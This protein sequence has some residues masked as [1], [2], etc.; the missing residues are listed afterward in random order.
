MKLYYQDD[1]VTLYHGDSLKVLPSLNIEAQV[2][3]TD[4]PYFK[5]KQDEWDNQ[6]DKASEFLG[7]MGSILDAAKPLLTEHASAWVFASPAMTSSVER[8]VGERF[9]VLNSIRWA[10]NGGDNLRRV[11]LPAIRSF[12]SIW[13]G[14][15][16]AE[17]F[18]DAYDAASKALRREVFTPLGDYLRAE[19]EHAGWKAGALGVALGYDSAMPS[20][21]AEGSS[22]PTASA[23]QRLR[24]TLNAAGGDYLAREYGDLVAENARLLAEFESQRVSIEH[25]RRPFNITDRKLSEDIWHFPSVPGYPGKHSC[26]KPLP[27]LRHMIEASSRPGDLVLDAFAGSGSTLDAARQTGRRAVGIEKDERW[28]EFIANRLAQD[29]LDLFGEAS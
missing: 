4:P 5:V 19:W 16:F 8:L 29:V 3:L 25:L 28:C 15:I 10:K 27:M 18:D 26:E 21:W 6:W 12:V 13:E 1:S 20:R 11:S 14:I 17:Q 9:R 23:Y 7:W 2:L 24:D 22:L